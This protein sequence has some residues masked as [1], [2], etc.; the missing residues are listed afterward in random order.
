MRIFSGCPLH[1]LDH[2]EKEIRIVWS[3]KFSKAGYREKKKVIEKAAET[4]FIFFSEGN[5]G[6]WCCGRGDDWDGI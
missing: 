3:K 4:I 2:G 1:V 6:I 5:V